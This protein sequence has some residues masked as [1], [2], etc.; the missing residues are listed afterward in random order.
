MTKSIVS[1][2]KHYK[3]H[4]AKTGNEEC[5]KL[6]VAQGIRF[7]SPSCWVIGKTGTVLKAKRRLARIYRQCLQLIQNFTY[8]QYLKRAMFELLIRDIVQQ[9][10]TCLVNAISRVQLPV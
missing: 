7:L 6:R 5:R 3:T 2:G 8:A 10:S 9:D 4:E 1:A